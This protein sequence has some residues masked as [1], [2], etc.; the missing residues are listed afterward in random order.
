MIP[1]SAFRD[2]LLKQINQM[3]GSGNPLF[4]VKLED[5]DELWNLYLDSF[6]DGDNE[7]FRTRREHDCSSCKH[8]IR[9]M[10]GVVSI[11][12][13]KVI[14]IWD[15]E[16]PGRYEPVAKALSE[17]VKGKPIE[18]R[19]ISDSKQIGTKEN[20]EMMVV[21][22]HDNIQRWD[23]LYTI[24][25]DGYVAKKRDIDT[26]KGK[27]RTDIEV[28]HRALEEISIGSVESVLELISQNSLYRGEEWKP[29]LKKFLKHLKEFKTLD[30]ESKKLYAFEKASSLGQDVLR[31]RNHSMGTLLVNLSGFMDLDIAVR[32]YESIVAPSNYKRPKAVITPRMI[33]EAQ[34]KVA[35]LGYEKSLFRRFATL[36]DITAANSLFVDRDVSSRLKNS[37]PFDELKTA[38]TNPVKFERVD[39]VTPEEFVNDILPSSRK[40]EI[41]FES[42]N[43]GN[44]MSLI[45][46]VHPE[47]KSMFKWD[48]GLSWAYTGNMAG[49]MKERVKS[50]GGNVEG[51]LRFTISWNEHGDNHN[52]FDAHAIEPGG[53]HIYY[54]IKRRVQ[55][56]SGMLDVDIIHPGHYGD[57]MAVENIIWTDVKRMPHGTYKLQ[58]HNFTHRGGK[59]GFRA[60]VEFEG[61]LYEF[62]YNHE[63][64]HNETVDV[65]EVDFDGQN[66]SIREKIPSRLSSVDIWG[67]KTNQFIPVSV[68]MHSPNHWSEGSGD[69]HL[70]FLLKGCVNPGTPNGFYNEFLDSDLIPHRKVFEALGSKMAV[71]PSDDQLS[72][73]GFSLTRHDEITVKVIG[74]VERI[75]KITI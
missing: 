39:K 53:V 41:L 25:P 8:F 48:N 61:K 22:G 72:G 4:E 42:K 52:D 13:G 30:E 28:F 51:V 34:K 9:R 68:I 62:D 10:A 36:E 43:K 7:I 44:L 16:A 66:F 59:S 20:F 27:L 46:P 49:S 29:A 23:H 2:G 57:V 69:K 64:R 58:V 1:F 37:N 33:E 71:E 38:A 50:L 21:D 67:L 60:E 75:I 26:L 55:R 3:I 5:K 14:S 32:K 31:I 12:D 18:G 65:A 17:H 54:P 15:F 45:A 56:S 11:K 74:N 73:L 24:L 63:L 47:S 19:F 70:F 40:I 35:E 6:E